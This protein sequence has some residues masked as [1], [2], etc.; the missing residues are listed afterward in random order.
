[1]KISKNKC[2]KDLS[3]ASDKKL[4]NMKKLQPW[5]LTLISGFAV[6]VFDKIW[7]N[8]IPW[9]ELNNIP[10][11]EWLNIKLALYQVLLF[12]LIF[13]VLYFIVK[14]FKK[15]RDNNDSIYTKKQNQLLNYNSQIID[16]ILWKWDI[17][18][19]YNNRPK[20]ANLQPYCKRH[21][22][23]MKMSPNSLTS[24]FCCPMC[25]SEIATSDF[26]TPNYRKYE[27]YIQSHLENEWEKIKI[28]N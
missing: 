16:N 10:V 6:Y 17:Y 1:M 12:I 14:K 9:Q 27:Q 21:E 3:I 11:I 13:I 18:F 2:Y 15:S 5:I 7:G 26:Y 23:P 28:N 4:I 20:L 19:E 22:P 8:R 25:N 24:N